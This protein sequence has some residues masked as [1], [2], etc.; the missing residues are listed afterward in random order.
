MNIKNVESMPWT[1]G[2]R[3][4]AGERFYSIIEYFG[5]SIN[6]SDKYK[7]NLLIRYTYEYSRSELSQ[8]IFLRY[9]FRYLERDIDSNEAI[10][11]D[12]N[13]LDDV[14]E[15]ADSLLDN[16]YFPLKST[17]R[18]TPQPFPANLS[19]IKSL[20][21]PHE[22]IG[23]P[24]RVSHLRAQCLARDH[25]RCVVSR[26]F[27]V[28]E[29]FKR[30]SKDKKALDDEGILLKGQPTDVLEVAHIIPHSLTQADTNSQLPE[31]KKTALAILNM[32]DYD[33]GHLINGTDID[34]PPN[35]LSL[36]P[37]CRTAFGNFD[38]YLEAVA[39][40]EHTYRIKTFSPTQEMLY[41]LPVTRKLFLSE[42][43]TVEPPSP[44]LLALHSA[45]AHVLHLS[46]AGEY[47]DKILGDFEDTGVRGNGTTEL[48]RL[49]KWRIAGWLHS[50]TSCS[51]DR[52]KGI[53]AIVSRTI[54]AEG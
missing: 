41:G 9:F 13:L 32:F 16:F 33:V 14:K 10:E 2:Q 26:S 1:A 12:E 8:D 27:D 20:Q 22:F 38:I 21:G 19:A 46:G 45:I 50:G 52:L 43:Y 25:Y 3:S 18:K 49:L 15:F 24:E 39:D 4:H 42:N 47:I 5:N 54:A 40:Q 28:N 17:G 53:L 51:Q 31:P 34:R 48:G 23:T 36:T 29:A 6:S 44:R 7:P 35:V 11:Y 37:K 30:L